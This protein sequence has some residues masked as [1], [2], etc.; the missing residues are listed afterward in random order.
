MLLAV[1]GLVLVPHLVPVDLRESHTDALGIIYTVLYFMFGVLIGFSACLVMN[2]Y[3]ASQS[4]AENEA[5][6]VRAI[7]R[8]AEQL[9]KPKRDE[10]QGAARAYAQAV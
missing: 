7:Y 6:D 2:K 8:I 5:G 4:A 1:A 9:P 10:I 3:I